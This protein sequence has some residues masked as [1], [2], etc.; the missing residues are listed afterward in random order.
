MEQDKAATLEGMMVASRMLLQAL[1]DYVRENVPHQQR[2]DIM[3]KIGTATAELIDISR[4]IYEEHPRLN[5]H[6]EQYQLA[7]RM[8]GEPT[9]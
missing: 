3:L 2:R 9:D 4:M 1:A 8:R 7:A 6:T 5:P